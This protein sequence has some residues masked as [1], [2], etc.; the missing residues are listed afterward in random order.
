MSSSQ[1]IDLILGAEGLKQKRRRGWMIKAGISDPESVADHSF[2]TTV[3][4]MIVG[5]V[6]GLNTER[7]MRMALFHDLAESITGDYL[8]GENPS[9][10]H[11][12]ELAMNDLLSKLP[13]KLKSD[14][15]KIW[16]EFKRCETKEAILVRQIDKLEMG[17]QASLYVKSGID[18]SILEDFFL[19]VENRLSEPLVRDLL[20]EVRRQK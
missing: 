3:I 16:D 5:D 18:P 20:R 12:E 8:P 1:L 7:I 17:L 4:G 19:S 13:V 15:M 6:L 14:Y 2:A 10:A 11:E 9:K